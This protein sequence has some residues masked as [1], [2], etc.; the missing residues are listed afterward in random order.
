[1]AYIA[2]NWATWA[3]AATDRLMEAGVPLVPF[4]RS[5]VVRLRMRLR[6]RYSHGPSVKER[7]WLLRALK[8]YDLAPKAPRLQKRERGSGEL[9]LT[10]AGWQHT[11]GAP[12]PKPPP[13]RR[14]PET[15]DPAGSPGVSG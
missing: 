2:A 13:I 8:R 6:D 10:P 15:W 7:D 1:M 9:P 12:P 3:R 4:D 14:P 5:W 11:P